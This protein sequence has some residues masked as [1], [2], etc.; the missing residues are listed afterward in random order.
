MEEEASESMSRCTPLPNLTSEGQV[1]LVMQGISLLKEGYLYSVS[2]Q[3]IMTN[4]QNIEALK[5]KDVILN[6][7]WEGKKAEK[8]V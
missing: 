2:K 1:F 7:G 5:R 6:I 3:S 4:V 8:P